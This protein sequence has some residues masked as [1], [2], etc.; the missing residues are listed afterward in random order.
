MIVDLPFFSQ[1]CGTQ[2]SVRR[3]EWWCYCKDGEVVL[4]ASWEVKR[5]EKGRRLNYH[6]ETS[7]S[8]CNPINMCSRKWGKNLT[9]WGVVTVQG[10]GGGSRSRGDAHDA[11][12][13]EV[14]GKAR[15]KSIQAC[16]WSWKIGIEK[17]EMWHTPKLLERFKCKFKNKNNGRRSWGTFLKSYHFGG[18]KGMLELWDWD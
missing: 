12:W 10:V 5:G 13:L 14:N 4:W 18:Q 9:W 3:K 15:K 16:C 11:W 17:V 6:E 7:S 8:K 1:V 2:R